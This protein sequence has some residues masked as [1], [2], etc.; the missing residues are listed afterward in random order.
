YDAYS[1]GLTSPLGEL[2]V[3]YADYALWECVRLE[4]GLLEGQ[5]AYW[6]RQLGGE[7]PAL[8]LP[9]DR[10]RPAS[11]TYAG[12]S[13]RFELSAPLAHGLRELCQSSD[14]TLYTLLL[15]AYAALLYRY[16]G[17]EEIL[18]GSPVAG[19]DRVELEGLVG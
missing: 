10:P 3:Q 2:P 1:R 7:L 13:H 15:A 4:G 12:A 16:T 11:A 5:L 8:E 6:R 14:V 19:R 17:Q 18:V 9:T